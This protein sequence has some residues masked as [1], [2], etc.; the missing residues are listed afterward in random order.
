[1]ERLP[2]IHRAACDGDMAEL[3]RLIAEDAGRLNARTQ[4]YIDTGEEDVDSGS[5][6]LMLAARRGHDAVVARLLALG[7][8][9]GLRDEFGV[10][11]TRTTC[12]GRHASTLALLLDAGASVNERDGDDGVGFSTLMS[13]AACKATECVKLVLARGAEV[14]TQNDYGQTALH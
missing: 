12:Y 2:H 7:A 6:P 3:D 9:I 5:I 14:D 1:M 13:A 8:D 11:A 10:T 4:V